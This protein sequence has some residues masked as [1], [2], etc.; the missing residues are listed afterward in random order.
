MIGYAQAIFQMA[1]DI[2]RAPYTALMEVTMTAEDFTF[3]RI[4][5]A[6]KNGLVTIVATTSI[7]G[8]LLLVILEIALGWNYFKLL[9]E[10]V[11]RYVVVGVLCYTLN[12]TRNVNIQGPSQRA[13]RAVVE[14]WKG[15]LFAFW[16]VD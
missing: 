12:S 1:L 6:L 16:S 11:E 2:A 3:A 5:E 15:Y 9:L 7:V 8:T 10:T 13:A 4:E 14:D